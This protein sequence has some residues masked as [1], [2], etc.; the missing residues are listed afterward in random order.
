MC[1]FDDQH[2]T[3]ERNAAAFLFF[4]FMAAL[5]LSGWLLS[6]CATTKVISNSSED[7][8]LILDRVHLDAQQVIAHPERWAPAVDSLCSDGMITADQCVR[9]KA[10]LKARAILVG[11]QQSR[12]RPAD[13]IGI[14]TW[15]ER[16]K[17][18]KMPGMWA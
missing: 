2:E 15:R 8:S 4:L 1:R 10:I 13:M 14:K 7:I 17:R 16:A 12:V 11:E 9:L 3:S 6:G 5:I 18:L